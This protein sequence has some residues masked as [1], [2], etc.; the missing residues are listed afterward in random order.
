MGELIYKSEKQIATDIKSKQIS[1]TEISAADLK[2]NGKALVG[3][4][5]PQFFR[6]I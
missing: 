3:W 5:P 1:A 6:S 4:K 2:H